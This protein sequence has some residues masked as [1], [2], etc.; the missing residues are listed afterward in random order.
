MEHGVTVDRSYDVVQVKPPLP[1]RVS[2]ALINGVVP[3]P[4]NQLALMTFGRD[5]ANRGRSFIEVPL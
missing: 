1:V 5:H 4:G 2:L 3:T